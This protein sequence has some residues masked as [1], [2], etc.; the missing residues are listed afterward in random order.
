MDGATARRIT[1]S[2]EAAALRALNGTYPTPLLLLLAPALVATEFAVVAAASKGGWRA[3]KVAAWRETVAELPRL[4]AERAE[5]QARRRVT[6][7]EFAEGLE[8]ELSSPYLGAAAS[9]APLRW[10]LR[11]YWAGVRGVLRL[12]RV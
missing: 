5:I 10:A 3:A 8:A 2:S 9:L 7:S 6:A 11:T 1:G 4:R 12:L